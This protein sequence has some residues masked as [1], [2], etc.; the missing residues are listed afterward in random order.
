M[1]CISYVC[2]CMGVLRVLW[3]LMKFRSGEIGDSKLPAVIASEC[4]RERL[5]VRVSVTLNVCDTL[6]RPVQGVLRRSHNV[7]WDM[8]QPS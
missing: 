4:E 3:F 5:S 1:L 7:C 8:L 2:I 6:V